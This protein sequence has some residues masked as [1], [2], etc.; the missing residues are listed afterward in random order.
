MGSIE[1]HCMEQV[2]IEMILHSFSDFCEFLKLAVRLFRET[3]FGGRSWVFY[4]NFH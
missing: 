3:L 4:W 1:N 2:N